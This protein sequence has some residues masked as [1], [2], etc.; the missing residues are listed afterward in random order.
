[1]ESEKKYFSQRA[2]SIATLFGGPLAAGYLVK[3]NYETLEQP[4]MGRWA[5]RIGIICTLFIYAVI[6]SLPEHVIDKMPSALIPGI[7]AGIIFIAVERLMGATLKSHKQSG[8]IFYSGWKA[9]G[10][11]AV[12]MIVL[13][14]GIG[15][16]AFVAGD[17][18]AGF[19]AAAYDQGV[20]KFIEN[21]EKAL[22]V[23]SVIET[24]P[25]DHLVNEFQK[26]ILLWNEN[27]QIMEQLSH[28]EELPQELV[29]Q[30]NL[31]LKYCELR[32]QHS[33]IFIRAI[34][35]D[36]DKY[37]PQIENIGAEINQILEDLN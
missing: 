28:I 19:D 1:M 6:F 10:I 36:T 26:G 17:F 2:I 25:P 9:A 34:I 18:S 22:A 15:L 4:E 11:G 14:A 5:M 3:K 8:G 27:I 13:V 20:A 16:A 12:S 37:F 31:L 21:E 32:V 30:N 35:E 24:H 29:A 23:F 33:Q 7:Y